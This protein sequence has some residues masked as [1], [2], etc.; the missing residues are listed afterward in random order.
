MFVHAP[1]LTIAVASQVVE[2]HPIE[3]AVRNAM[4]DWFDT[5]LTIRAQVGR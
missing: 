3:D 5:E 1:A 4:W 2:G